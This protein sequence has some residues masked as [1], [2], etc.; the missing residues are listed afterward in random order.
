MKA[1]QRFNAD[2]WA[3]G[4]DAPRPFS[5]ATPVE[6]VFRNFS[7]QAGTGDTGFLNCGKWHLFSNDAKRFQKGSQNPEDGNTY[8]NREHAQCERPLFFV[9]VIQLIPYSINGGNNLLKALVYLL[10]AL[11]NICLGFIKSFVNICFAF[12]AGVGPQQL[13]NMITERANNRL[14][15]ALRSPFLGSK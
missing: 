12:R 4:E 14:F 8:G 13:F 1:I 3:N 6:W 11:V 15:L 10:K 2:I 9:P 5:E 7:W